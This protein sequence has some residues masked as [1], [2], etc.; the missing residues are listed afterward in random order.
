MSPKLTGFLQISVHQEV[1][2]IAGETHDDPFQLKYSYELNFPE[3]CA[4]N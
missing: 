3:S 1:N 2:F 4:E